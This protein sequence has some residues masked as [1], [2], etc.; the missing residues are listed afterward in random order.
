MNGHLFLL[1]R[2]NSLSLFIPEWHPPGG[3]DSFMIG[4]EVN[5]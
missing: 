4:I 1:G 3:G 2:K 5:P